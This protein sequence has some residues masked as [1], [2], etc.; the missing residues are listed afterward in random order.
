VRHINCGFQPFF[1]NPQ[2]SSHKNPVVFIVLSLA[3]RNDMAEPRLPWQPGTAKGKESPDAADDP[4]SRLRAPGKLH[5]FNR[6]ELKYLLPRTLVA[7]VRAELTARMQVD[8][9]AGTNGYGVWSLYYDTGHLLFYW[10][11][12]EGLKFRRKLR[13][14]RYGEVGD[15]V[16]DDAPVSVEI[17]QRVNRVTQK[18]RVILPYTLARELCDRRVRIEQVAAGRAKTG[19]DQ[20][21]SAPGTQQVPA[22]EGVVQVLH[23]RSSAM[24]GGVGERF[25]SA[26]GAPRF[27]AMRA[28]NESSVGPATSV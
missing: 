18:R 27:A 10:E 24:S 14:R 26:L 8:A 7:D 9:H 21:G 17:K 11:K 23:G 4:G 5:A 6:Y 25:P 16:P 15:D 2:K 13:I 20:C 12:I 19:R 1:S 22:G 3:R 28:L